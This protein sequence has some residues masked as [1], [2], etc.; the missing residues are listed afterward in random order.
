MT[1][2]LPLLR[3]TWGLL[4]LAALAAAPWFDVGDGVLRTA[5]FRLR[6]PR[7]PPPELVILDVDEASV[8]LPERLT[9]QELARSP[10]WRQMGA[11][12][13]PRALQAELAAL[14]L[15]QGARQVVFTL[16]YSQPSSYGPAD[17]QA[18]LARLAPWRE[19]VVLVVGYSAEDDPSAGLE[20]VKL[21]QPVY[22]LGRV[23]LDALLEGPTGALE[24]IPGRRWQQEALAGL[25]TP[26]PPALAFAAA[27]RRP[28]LAPLGLDYPG[29]AGT[30]PVVPAWQVEQQPAGF[31]HNRVVVFGRTPSRLADRRSSP[32]GP[33]TAVELQAVALA[34]VL[35]GHGFHHLPLGAAAVLLVGWGVLG[36]LVLCRPAV[37]V[38]TGAAA[39]LLALAG[40]GIGALGWLAGWW[41]P[42]T[43]LVLAPLLGGGS[44]ALG[45][46]LAE[47]RE[48]AYL[49]QVLARR[50]SPA[51][52]ADILREPG[53]LGTQLGGSRVC[54]AVLFTDLVGF[55]ALS[56][57]LE[58]APLFAL[59]N[60]YFEAVAA[61]VIA[62]DGLVDKF[63][64][65][66]LMAEF[67]VPRS[68][69]AAEDALAAVRAALAM[70]VALEQLNRELA[71]QQRSPL[72]QAI[73]IHVG[74]L[75]AG[76]LGSSQRLE[77]TV[78]GATVNL[79][80]RL[81]GLANRF[82]AFPAL[83][84]DAV[85]ELL[86]G[87]LDVQPLGAHWLKGWP[88]PVAVFGLRGLR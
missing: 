50:V 2:R 6:G 86:P 81:V 77:F 14:V 35:E 10:L 19:R 47:S 30:V 88:E 67:G 8:S 69:G 23:G 64:G 55:T 37:A 79:A 17:D 16:L 84:S 41:L 70:Q 80:S 57:R 44:R 38:G 12:P 65:D 27:R 7:R 31:W 78:V 52:L 33:L 22:H 73:G 53:P 34:T 40:I 83:I 29:P 21:H 58:P 75:I 62:E 39:L 76:N 54:C 51:L 18:F 3:R 46:W 25:P 49:R 11:W 66:S 87:L 43:A 5:A 42:V 20:L 24:A 26:H 4:F 72:R 48:R 85:V 13:W 45:Q 32:F 68:R 1:T 9:P 60:R 15:R 74:E 82:P 71:Q 63:I 59:L 61:A 36:L 28:S 56:A